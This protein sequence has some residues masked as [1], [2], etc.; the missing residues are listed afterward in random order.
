MPRVHW[1]QYPA[2]SHVIAH[3]SDTHLLGSGS[4]LYGA[5]DVEGHLRQTLERLVASASD[6]DVIVFTGD[7]VDAGQPEAYQR[8]RGLVDPVARRLGAE[9]VWVMGNH[10]ERSAFRS[11]LLDDARSDDRAPVDQVLTVRGLRIIALDTSIPGWHHGRLEP[12]QLDWLT[13]VL[14]DPAE[15]GSVITLHHPPIPTPIAAMQ[16]L[17]LER[18][19]ELAAVIEGTDV[20]G[21]LGGH[22]HYA[23]SGTFAG[24]PVSV[25][26]ATCYTMD[27]GAPDGELVG[28]DAAQAFNLVQIY[29]GRMVSSVVPLRGGPVVTRFGAEFIDALDPLTPEERLER[30]SRQ[31][32]G[33]GT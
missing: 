6:P 28:I 24:V 29:D 17:E 25:A 8:L 3:I 21:V 9:V 14:A 22:L 31:P 15:H 13:E 33:S 30:F 26:A 27:L 12:A 10:D 5:V 16:V 18:Q 20:I 23:T 19:D 7:L 4:A 32:D 1:G 2:P 11:Q